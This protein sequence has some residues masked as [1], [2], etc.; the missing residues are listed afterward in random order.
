M[1]KLA[2]LNWLRF[3][4]LLV[5]TQNFSTD[6][7]IFF[8]NLND[9]I[10]VVF[11]IDYFLLIIIVDHIYEGKCNPLKT[12]FDSILF[13]KSFDEWLEMLKP[14]TYLELHIEKH[15]CSA[16]LLDY[17]VMQL[18]TKF[19]GCSTDTHILFSC[20]QV[21]TVAPIPKFGQALNKKWVDKC[22]RTI[23]FI[24]FNIK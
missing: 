6:L 1:I 3:I 23:K 19:Q 4:A 20:G 5:L 12:A 18:F 16:Q 13:F 21:S 22:K 17:F 7:Q 11:F 2:C 24:C 14:Q 15:R 10:V 8:L 9:L